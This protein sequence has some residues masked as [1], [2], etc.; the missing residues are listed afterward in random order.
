MRVRHPARVYDR[1][2]ASDGCAQLRRKLFQNLKVLGRTDAAAAGNDD[3]G[4]PQVDRLGHLVDALDQRGVD[5]LG[6]SMDFL[7][8]HLTRAAL[9]V[10]A[11]LEHAGAYR[12]H[13]RTVL[14]THNNRHQVAAKGRAGP[15]D[16]AG[17]LVD[18]NRRTVGCQA[19][20]QAAGNARPQ[21]APVVG[22]AQHQGFRLVLL[23]QRGQRLRESVGR[24]I[25]VLRPVYDNRG[26]RAVADRVLRRLLDVLA[27]DHGNQRAALLLGQRLSGGNQLIADVLRLAALGFNE[28]PHIFVIVQIAHVQPLLITASHR[29]AA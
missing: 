9:I 21:V 25:L 19:G 7:A 6:G 8:D 5:F 2:A 14:G 13:L 17:F 10:S 11:L 27:D 1:A 3:F 22:R 18:I 23:D 29:Q 26:I 20:F 28:Y 16:V 12:A 15:R 24:V 4:F